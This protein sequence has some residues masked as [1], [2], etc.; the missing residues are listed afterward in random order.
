M[1]VICYL[2]GTNHAHQLEGQKDGD[3]VSFSKYLSAFCSGKRVDL[4]AEELNEECI[5]KWQAVGSVAKSVASKLSIRHLFCD[6]GSEDRQRLGV[7]SDQDVAKKLGFG[8]CWTLQQA[9]LIETEVRKSWPVRETFWLDRLRKIG[10]SRCAFVLGAKH[11]V[12]FNALLHAHGFTGYVVE[13][14]WEP[15][16]LRQTLDQKGNSGK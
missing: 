13:T 9:A 10:F 14:N 15:P 7:L 8:S 5:S 4:I 6:P 12:T 1:T 3:S 11:I 2:I 16:K